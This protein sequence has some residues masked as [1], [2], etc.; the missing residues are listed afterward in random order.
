MQIEDEYQEGSSVAWRNLALTLLALAVYAAIVWTFHLYL[1]GQQEHAPTPV[2]R[3]F[4][5]VMDMTLYG[6][7]I[8]ALM[9]TQSVWLWNLG[10]KIVAAQRYPAPGVPVARRMKI[11][12]GTRAVR[13]GRFL[14]FCA[15]VLA[16]SGCGG[17]A[18][19]I[20]ALM[21]L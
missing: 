10:R 2:R 13:T 15:A 1:D 4:W 8:A 18:L 14:Q 7:S 16:L 5:F 12:W 17:I 3:Y 21:S 6:L 20:Y 11:Q 19:A 9:L